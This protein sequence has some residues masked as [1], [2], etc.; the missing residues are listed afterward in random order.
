MADQCKSIGVI[1]REILFL[2]QA[3][4]HPTDLYNQ[5]WRASS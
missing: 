4:H 2:H 1:V 3:A 5:L